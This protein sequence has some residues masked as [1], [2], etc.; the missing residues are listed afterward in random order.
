[1]KINPRRNFL[2]LSASHGFVM[3]VLSSLLKYVLWR[4]S[5]IVVQNTTVDASRKLAKTFWSFFSAVLTWLFSDFRFD[6]RPR[7]RRRR[8]LH[9][10]S[11]GSRWWFFTVISLM[12]LTTLLPDWVLCSL[13]RRIQLWRLRLHPL[14]HLKLG[15]PRCAAPSF[16]KGENVGFL[17]G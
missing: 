10:K 9:D 15:I 5:L 1:M 11:S 13:H 7:T 4:K 14:S 3:I 6:I 16:S 8:S 17:F 12:L 2:V